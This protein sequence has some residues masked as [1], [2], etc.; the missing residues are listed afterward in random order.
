MEE[1]VSNNKEKVITKNSLNIAKFLNFIQDDDE[2]RR[3]G[4]LMSEGWHESHIRDYKL[5]FQHEIFRRY[6]IS[7]ARQKSRSMDLNLQILDL[8]MLQEF[9]RGYNLSQEPWLTENLEEDGPITRL[10]DTP[11]RERNVTISGVHSFEYNGGIRIIEFSMPN[12]FTSRIRFIWDDDKGWDFDELIQD[13]KKWLIND[14]PLIG[15]N[16]DILL[17]FIMKIDVDYN[18]EDVVLTKK[19]E[20]IIVNRFLKSIELYK[21]HDQ[22]SIKSSCGLLMRGPPGC[23]KTSITRAVINTARKLGT[24]AIFVRPDDV[25][26]IGD[27]RRAYQIARDLA[28]CIVVWE[29]IDNFGTSRRFS[30]G[31]GVLPLLL[32][33]LDGSDGNSG[34]F[35]IASTNRGEDLDGALADRPGRFDYVVE[36]GYPDQKCCAKLLA[37]NLEEFGIKYEF[38]CEKFA[39]K[40]NGF[41]GA[42]IKQV[43]NDLNLQLRN[44]VDCFEICATEKDLIDAIG[45]VNE[46]RMSVHKLVASEYRNDE[47]DDENIERL[48]G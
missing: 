23:G 47:E 22:N 31:G 40:I 17:N 36:I 20:E 14:S 28:P 24:T 4:K 42:W 1:V 25:R 19:N 35:T 41:S 37:I 39:Q 43:V 33:I 26:E 15:A 18:L 27:I 8:L 11:F 7:P 12:Y 34:V 2:I 10:I 6:S 16:L 13:Y 38:D 48:Y 21:I 30:K 44:L 46:A 29:D 32:D 5:Q 9:L 3:V 45:R